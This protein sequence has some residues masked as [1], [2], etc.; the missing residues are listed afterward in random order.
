MFISKKKFE[1][2]LEQARQSVW[3]IVDQRRFQD[4]M[5]HNIY[6]IK[7]RLDKLEGKDCACNLAVETP[8][9]PTCICRGE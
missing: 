1:K 9:T 5:W 6:E 7:Q 8:E 2:E 3:D 4:Y